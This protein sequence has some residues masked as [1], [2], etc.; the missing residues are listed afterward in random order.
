[1]SFLKRALTNTSKEEM[2]VTFIGISISAFLFI[3]QII[4][5]HIEN[6]LS[7][8]FASAMTI[9]SVFY[10]KFKEKRPIKSRLISA[11]FAGAFVWQLIEA[12]S[13]LFAKWAVWRF[14]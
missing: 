9:Y 14:F 7:L 4:P 10:S 12:S 2:I 11:M 6:V 1:M 13:K 3:S 8:S 5:R